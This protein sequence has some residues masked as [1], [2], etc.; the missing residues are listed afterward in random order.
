MHSAAAVKSHVRRSRRRRG[1]RLATCVL[2]IAAG[3]GVLVATSQTPIEAVDVQRALV[4]DRATA[5]RPAVRLHPP[6]P[7]SGPPSA[8]GHPSAATTGVPAGVV[9]TPSS[10]IT[11]TR[12]GTILDGLDI[13]GTVTINV[14]DVTIRRSRI[15]GSDFASVYVKDGVTGVVVEDV[16]INGQGGSGTANSMG[17]YGP[18]TVRRSN[19]S[20]VENGVTPFS[21][22]VVQDNYIHHLAAPGAP[23]YD[24]I[25]IDGGVSNVVV[26]HNTIDLSEHDQTSAVMIDNYFGGIQNISVTGNL[27]SG[28]GYTVYCDGQFTGGA[29]N[30]V[31]FTGNVFNRGDFGYALIRN[32]SP[33]WSGNTDTAGR[34]VNP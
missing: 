5:S 30:G 3:G 28:G 27:V 11:V 29:I 23:H 16:E 13:A 1:R 26:G 9:L 17:V 2:A 22:S 20:G 12:P 7:A 6:A 32:C 34:I 25:Q 18:A 4:N 33:V 14:S 10:S 31:S 19:I 21:G 8:G 24:G 15:R